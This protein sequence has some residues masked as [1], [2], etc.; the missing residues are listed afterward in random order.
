M[1]NLTISLFIIL[2]AFVLTV[3]FTAILISIF[4]KRKIGQNILEIGP[5]WHI[6]KSGTPTMGGISFLIVSFIVIA[7]VLVLFDINA[8][9]IEIIKI[10]NLI[11]YGILNGLIGIIDDIA[12][13]RKRK[14][15]GLKPLTKLI[16]Q[17]IASI[18]FLTFLSVTVGIEKNILIPSLNLD[19]KLGA[20]YYPLAVIVLCGFVNA[21]NLT[22][23]VDGLAA[24]VSLTTGAFFFLIANIF[25]DIL[26]I[27]VVGAIIIGIALGFLIFNFYPAKIFM[28]DTGSLF[29][30]AI[31]SGCS[32]I[33]NNVLLLLVYG[34]VFLIEALSVI[35]QVAVFKLN[36]RKRLFLMAPLHH[37]FEK[38]GWSEIKIVSVFTGVNA[39]F[40]AL[41]LLNFK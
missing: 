8:N 22:D 17:F 34:F 9:R 37:H 26:S 36:K 40:C 11:I 16:L 4:R 12:K 13:Y 24:S 25:V 39:I 19:L 10:V 28:G 15:E 41:A 31:I 21:V 7:L 3:I 5:H 23:G 27:S 2:I 6:K 1:N 20:L 38:K 14:N 32:I 35:L 29:L 33:M 30:G 18:L